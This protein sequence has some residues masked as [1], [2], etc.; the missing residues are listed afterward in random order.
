VTVE[1]GDLKGETIA[2]AEILIDDRGVVFITAPDY[3]VPTVTVVGEEPAVVE[4]EVLT[5]AVSTVPPGHWWLATQDNDSSGHEVEVWINDQRVVTYGSGQGPRIV[6]LGK[7][8]QFGDNTV[9]MRSRSANVE[10]GM[11][12]VH[13]G[14]GGV[15]DGVV[16]MDQPLAVQ[17][18]LAASREGTYERTYRLFVDEAL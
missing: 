13:V 1:T 11:L 16:H 14:K 4:G 3:A 5:D 6:D 18:G 15:R 12:W 8:L 7:D 10:G 9:T 2:S 17:F